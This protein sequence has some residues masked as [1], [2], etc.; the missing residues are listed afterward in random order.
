MKIEVKFCPFGCDEKFVPELI[1]GKTTTSTKTHGKR[2]HDEGLEDKVKHRV[3]TVMS[4]INI[5]DINK[6]RQDY[7]KS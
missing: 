6:F 3:C 1:K 7:K 4:W 2:K 5:F